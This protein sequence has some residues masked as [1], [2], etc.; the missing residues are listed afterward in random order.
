M[1]NPIKDEFDKVSLEK[2]ISER[3]H[4]IQLFQSTGVLNRN[5]AINKIVNLRMSDKDVTEITTA[6]LLVSSTPF[7]QA[8]DSQI[9]GE[10]IMQRDVLLAKLTKITSEEKENG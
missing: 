10:L 2:D 1:G 7:S 4:I 5:D 3:E 9:V 6:N 8:T